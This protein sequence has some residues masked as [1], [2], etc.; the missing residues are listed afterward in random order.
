M[1]WKWPDIVKYVTEHGYLNEDEIDD[2]DAGNV[3]YEVERD[4]FWF[5]EQDGLY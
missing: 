3:V 2:M 4:Y 5:G 1:I